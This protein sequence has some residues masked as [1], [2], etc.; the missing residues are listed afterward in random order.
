[1]R[2]GLSHLVRLKGLGGGIL[3]SGLVNVG[4][5]KV[6]FMVDVKGKTKAFLHIKKAKARPGLWE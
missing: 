3:D 4:D 6:M 5:P 1:V 2:P